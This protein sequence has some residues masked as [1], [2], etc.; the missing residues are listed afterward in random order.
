MFILKQSSERH[1]SFALSHNK[2]T[3]KFKIFNAD[4]N[5]KETLSLG[6]NHFVWDSTLLNEQ[7][8]YEHEPNSRHL[9]DNI[10]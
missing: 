5:W 4:A 9:A 7:I 2:A 8:E 1:D 3:I 6:P 10:F